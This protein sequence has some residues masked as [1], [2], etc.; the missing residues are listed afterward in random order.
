M[1]SLQDK[2]ASLEK[3]L[4]CYPK[5]TSIDPS[6]KEVTELMNKYFIM[7]LDQ[8]MDTGNR[9]KIANERKWRQWVDN[10]LVHTLR[11]IFYGLNM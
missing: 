6:G 4:A 9:K 10:V 5:I 8:E 11:L 2:T 1:F 3:V 7:Y